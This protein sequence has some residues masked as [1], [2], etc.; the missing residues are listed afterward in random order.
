MKEW[1]SERESEIENGSHAFDMKY[2][3]M[4]WKKGPVA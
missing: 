3:M 1:A 2:I 4:D